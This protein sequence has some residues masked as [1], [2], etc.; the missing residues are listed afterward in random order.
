MEVL[1]ILLILEGELSAQILQIVINL[2]P[3]HYRKNFP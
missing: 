1:P 2:A 3:H